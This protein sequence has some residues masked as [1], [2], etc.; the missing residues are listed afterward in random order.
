MNIELDDVGRRSFGSAFEENESDNEGGDEGGCC[1]NW[2][3][4]SQQLVENA[5]NA[6]C[7]TKL[8]EQFEAFRLWRRDNCPAWCGGG[9]AND[10][11][12][13]K[14][15]E[16]SLAVNVVC[17]L[18]LILSS[19]LMIMSRGILSIIQ[20][21]FGVILSLEGL[22]AFGTDELGKVWT[23][24]VQ[25]GVFCL[26]SLFLSGVN[27]AFLDQY[28]SEAGDKTEC[29][30]VSEQNIS[31]NVG[32]ALLAFVITFYFTSRHYRLKRKTR[33]EAQN[34]AA[35]AGRADPDVKDSTASIAARRDGLFEE[36]NTHR[37]GGRW[38]LQELGRGGDRKH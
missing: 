37:Q 22:T 20:G 12:V 33:M 34:G 13:D 35:D 21:T 11:H 32:V 24:N 28:C 10:D 23:F 8:D 25:M 2:G 4:A 26:V 27:Y 16:S 17:M 14:L 30:R 31:A 18:Q 38:G 19:M 9:Q 6:Q 1:G 15:R 29:R 3:K 5:A 7:C 36:L